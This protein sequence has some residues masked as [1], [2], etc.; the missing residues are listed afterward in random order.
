MG[1]VYAMYAPLPKKKSLSRLLLLLQ[2][3]LMQEQR[4][5]ETVISDLY[6]T[7]ADC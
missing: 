3:L 7:I 4:L 1:K 2:L 5:S 6:Y